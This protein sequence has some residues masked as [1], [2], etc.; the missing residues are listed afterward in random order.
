MESEAKL[1]DTMIFSNDSV[2]NEAVY[3]AG[4]VFDNPKAY[5]T[6][7]PFKISYTIR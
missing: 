2:N 5:E 3:L 4:I 7:I 6:A 1:V